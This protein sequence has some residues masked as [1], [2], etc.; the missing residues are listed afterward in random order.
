MKSISLKFGPFKALSDVSVNFYAG[1]LVGLVGDNG[2]GKTSL[3]NILCGIHSPTSGE[4]YVDG[5]RIRKFRPKQAI[6][7]GIETIQQSVG[8]C[9]NLSVARNYFLGREPVKR[10]LGIPFLDFAKMRASSRKVI[11][12]F[13]L[14]EHVDVDDEVAML[15]GGERQSFKIGRAVDFRNRIM[16]LDEPTNHLS[17]RER[18]H[19]NDLAVQLKEQGL[20]VIY[21]THDIFQIHRL[22]DRIVIMENGK[23]VVDVA[24]S[25]MSAEELEHVI[26]D[27]GRVVESST[28]ETPTSRASS[29]KAP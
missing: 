2:A 26:R 8:L 23:K 1:E 12:S 16:I 25:E 18:Q 20:L 3:I 10:I 17:V 7:L 24:K 29:V 15:S 19:V 28:I 9:P 5:Q 21:I 6:D 22:A 4:V 13:G 27:G 11:R 14:R